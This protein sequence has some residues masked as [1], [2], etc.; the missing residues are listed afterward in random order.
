MDDKRTEGMGHQAKGTV[1]EAAG[2]LTGDRSQELEG[3]L[4]KNAGKLER[5]AGELQDDLRREARD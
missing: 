5:K 3:N 2:K 1:K 4:Q